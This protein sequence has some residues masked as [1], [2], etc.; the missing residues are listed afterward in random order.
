MG[1]EGPKSVIW[2]M[3]IENAGIELSKAPLRVSSTLIIQSVA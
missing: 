1:P 2:T 3:R